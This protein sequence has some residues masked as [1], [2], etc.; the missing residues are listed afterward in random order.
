MQL[1]I[2]I[3]NRVAPPG[4]LLG[5][6]SVEP[7]RHQPVRAFL[8]LRRAGG[9]DVGV[10]VLGVPRMTLDPSPLD[11]V[12]GRGLDQFLPELLI[13]EDSALA[14]PSAR[15]PPRHPPA[16]PL[17]DELRVRHGPELRLLPP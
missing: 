6:P 14:L 1:L 7:R 3:V 15:F 4:A 11:L 8:T 16:H 13:L 17:A 9:E 2:G 10:F 12:R 5:E